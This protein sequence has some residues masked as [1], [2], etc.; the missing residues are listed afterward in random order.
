MEFLIF[1]I[2]S[3][4]TVGF[5]ALWALHIHRHPSVDR[6]ISSPLKLITAGVFIASL[7]M[8]I[9]VCYDWIGWKDGYTYIRPVLLAILNAVRIFLAGVEFDI[10]ENAVPAAPVW[11]KVAYCLYAAI[12]YAVAPILTFSNVLSLFKNMTGEMRLRTCRNRPIYIMSELNAP[13]VTLA[14]S[15]VADYTGKRR[16]RPLIVFCDVFVQNEEQNYELLQQV[17]QLNAI[18]LKK[19]ASHVTFSRKGRPMEFFLIGEN[20]VENT[21]Q[22]IRLTEKWKDSTRIVSLYVFSSDPTTDSILDSID[23]GHRLLH[24]DVMDTMKQHL[25]KGL[26]EQIWQTADYEMSGGF[27]V[28]RIDPVDVLVQDVLT[29]NDYADYIEIQEAAQQTK[30]ISVT[31]LGMGRHGVHFLKTALWFYQRYGIRLEFNIFDMGTENGDPK[32]RLGQECPELIGINPS[33]Q[34]GDALYDIRFFTGVDCFSCDFN[35]LVLHDERQRFEKTNLVFVALGDDDRNIRAA[36]MVQTLFARLQA[37]QADPRDIPFIYSIVCDDGKAANLNSCPADPQKKKEAAA[38]RRIR[39]IGA[40]LDRY[41]YSVLRNIKY[42]ERNA[43]EYHLDWLKK[44]SQL[45]TTYRIAE[46]GQPH[47]QLDICI[48]FKNELDQELEERGTTLY[49][50]DTNYFSDGSSHGIVDKMV[51]DLMESYMRYAYFRRS[52]QAKAIH[53]K[54]LAKIPHIIETCCNGPICNCDICRTSRLTEHMRWNAYMR[55]LGYCHNSNGGKRDPLAKLHPDLCP[56]YE[57]PCKERYKD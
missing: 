30:T 9:P 20:E 14:N 43:F 52:S 49:W 39:Y 33:T 22:V 3:V 24:A 57:L 8:F 21:E 34:N 5:S 1:G 40:R 29:K 7:L 4:L 47:P 17:R 35:N 32:K 48:A 38:F 10:V 45:H 25:T 16:N 50:G 56:W 11:C 23:I 2:L 54:A 51:V 41:S 28:R 46:S 27:F 19:D 42:D 53:K 12:L 31:I 13:S 37:T 6:R 55:S 44:E 18:C 26:V 36:M 15:I